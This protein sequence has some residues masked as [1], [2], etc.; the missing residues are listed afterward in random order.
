LG[1]TKPRKEIDP[2][3]PQEPKTGG[4]KIDTGKMRTAA[5][6]RETTA[7]KLSRKEAGA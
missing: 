7:H 6:K 3:A 5:G 1:R 2:V 4:Q